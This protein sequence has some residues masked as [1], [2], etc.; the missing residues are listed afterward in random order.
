VPA[1]NRV[2]AALAAC[3]FAAAPAAAHDVITTNLTWTQEVSRIVYKHCVSCHRDG[4]AAPM[5]LVTYEQA[6]PWAK[7]IRDE[8]LERRMPP[9]GPVKGVGLFRHDPSLSQP[10]I[11]I[12]VGWVEGGAPNGDDIYLPA[13]PAAPGAAGPAPRGRTLAVAPN[14]T[15]PQT[16]HVA[17]IQP[18]GVPEHGSFEV[19]AIKPDGAIDRLLWIR[20]F[21]ARWNRTYVLD[22]PVTLPRGTRLTVFAAPGAS[23]AVIAVAKPAP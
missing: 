21:R 15:L 23:A 18:R 12:L 7:A 5:P 1:T 4:G 13:V 11:D 17:A 22:A 6:R 2:R 16:T 14:L 3:L 9:W 8:V 19:A 20:D 10:E